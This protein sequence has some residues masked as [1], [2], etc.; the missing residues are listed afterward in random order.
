MKTSTA[1][2]A[3]PRGVYFDHIVIILMENQGY[4]QIITTCGG[5]GTY[6]TTLANQYSIAGKCES[7]SAC[8]IGGYTAIAHRSEPNYAAI[9]SGGIY[10][11]TIGQCCFQDHHQN[12]VDR[13][14]SS[15]LTWQA[16]AED[17]GNSGMCS[18]LPQV[19]DSAHYPFIYYADNKVPSR[20][21]N[22]LSTS[23]SSGDS[24]FLNSLNT[25]SDWPNFIWLTPNNNDNGETSTV[26]YGDNYLSNLVPKI[27]NSTMFKSSRSVLFITYDE[28]IIKQ[29]CSPPPCVDNST[30]AQYVYA[31]LSGPVVKNGYVGTGSYSHYSLLA[32]LEANWGFPPLNSTNDGAANVMSEFFTG[33]RSQG[34][35][36]TSS[37][38]TLT[39]HYYVP[40]MYYYIG[41][42]GMIIAAVGIIGL[43]FTK[44]KRLV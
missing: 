39:S 35:S 27:L 30:Q 6:E 8:S 5:L 41:A 15:G 43:Y 44:R 7:D 37:D 12:I 11:D 13:L 4:C 1:T 3:T 19:N 18:F 31:S 17:A 42:G 23:S 33:A 9:I 14:E 2:S 25:A 32:T 40:A 29:G 16:Y 36:S 26:K 34:T 10:S 20:C 24:E 22:F 21:A 28:G 38:A